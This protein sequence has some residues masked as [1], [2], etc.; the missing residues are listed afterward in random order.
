MDAPALCC[1]HECL[2]RV[3]A[4][5]LRVPAAGRPRSAVIGGSSAG[6]GFAPARERLH[7]G[8]RVRF[9]GCA[10]VSSDGDFDPLIMVPVYLSIEDAEVQP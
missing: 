9:V 1:L 5:G 2:G 7:A 3:W 10:Q 6:L 8:A 4:Q